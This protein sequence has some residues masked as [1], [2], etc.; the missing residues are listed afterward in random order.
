MLN[1][2]SP[3]PANKVSNETGERFH[4]VVGAER[5]DQI[6][7]KEYGDAALWRVIASANQLVNPMLLEPG[8]VLRIPSLR[9]KSPL[10]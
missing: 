6:A 2:E 9:G 10:L 8:Y 5:I 4:L 7:A 3:S 1:R